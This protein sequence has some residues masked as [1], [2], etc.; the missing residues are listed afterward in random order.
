MNWCVKNY[1]SITESV[2]LWNMIFF[3]KQIFWLT[4]HVN[5]IPA[6]VQPDVSL[7]CSENSPL[8][9]V[10][11]LLNP[12]HTFTPYFLET[13]PNIILPTA[14]RFPQV[15]SSLHFYVQNFVYK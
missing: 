14:P 2:T 6:F 10:L 8:D 9:L 7:P 15:V 1:N 5:K 4:Q 11:S 12:V 3:E 13:H